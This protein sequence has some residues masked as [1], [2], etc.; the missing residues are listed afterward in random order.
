[1]GGCQGE[2]GPRGLS[3]FGAPFTAYEEFESQTQSESIHYGF[4][5]LGNDS[6]AAASFLSPW[7]NSSGVAGITLTVVGQ[8]TALYT[9]SLS[10]FAVRHS[11]P[12]VSGIVTYEVWINGGASGVSLAC[13]TNTAMCSNFTA[14]LQVTEG[15]ALTIRCTNG[16]GVGGFQ[17]S[18]FEMVLTGQTLPDFALDWTIVAL[19]AGDPLPVQPATYAKAFSLAGEARHPGI[20][21]LDTGGT[22][23]GIVRVHQNVA[24]RLLG[25]GLETMY[26]S[27]VRVPIL[28][29]VNETFLVEFGI[30]DTFAGIPAAAVL[31]FY[32]PTSVNWQMATIGAASTVVDSG[33]PVTTD[34]IKLGI[35]VTDNTSAEF[36]ID[37]ASVGVIAAN[38]PAVPV[39]YGF[40]IQKL[41]GAAGVNLLPRFFDLDYYGDVN[42]FTPA[43]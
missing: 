41:G 22:N 20:L 23:E 21:R 31:F 5:A 38:M 37:G 11:N 16:I 39:G 43:R 35:L 32:D 40:V 24:A 42:T 6:T 15:D 19:D 7:W 29:D 28:N 17:R 36:F 25:A 9:G 3:G 12:A 18:A 26:E 33:V 14:Q 2:R 10:H 30:A 13:D 1:M 34:W 27:V 4:G 8:L